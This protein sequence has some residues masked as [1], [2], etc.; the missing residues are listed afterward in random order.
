LE[1]R[2]P[3]CLGQDL[4]QV[5]LVRGIEVADEQE[6]Q[7]WVGWEVLEQ[8]PEGLQPARRAA[9]T[10]DGEGR[11]VYAFVRRGGGTGCRGVSRVRS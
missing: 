2:Q 7:P 1:D 8:F 4:R 6:R 5:A 9:D 11:A 10:D 3:S